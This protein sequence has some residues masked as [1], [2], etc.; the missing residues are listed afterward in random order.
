MRVELRG[1]QERQEEQGRRVSDNSAMIGRLADGVNTRFDAIHQ[2]QHQQDA[3]LNEIGHHF[4]TLLERASEWTSRL[5]MLE[6]RPT[7]SKLET[8]GPWGL[9]AV[10][11]VAKVLGLDLSGYLK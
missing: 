9:I 11:L 4:K 8:I 1:V 7:P 5:T 3:R 10:A 6:G 2:R